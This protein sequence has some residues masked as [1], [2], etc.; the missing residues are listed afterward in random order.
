MDTGRTTFSCALGFT[1]G[2]SWTIGK[3]IAPSVKLVMAMMLKFCGVF[4]GL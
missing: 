3:S 2:K 1:R 4:Y